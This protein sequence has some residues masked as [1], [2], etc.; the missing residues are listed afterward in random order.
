M[1]SA[2]NS[3]HNA[4]ISTVILFPIERQRIHDGEK[5]P[6][7]CYFVM[8]KLKLYRHGDSYLVFWNISVWGAQCNNSM[9]K[10]YLGSGKLQINVSI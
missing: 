10:R 1:R 9:Y 7:R 3:F 6:N 8:R 5:N 2:Q 4:R